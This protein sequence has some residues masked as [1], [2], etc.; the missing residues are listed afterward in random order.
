MILKQIIE[1]D[2][3]NY[4]R[5]S[6]LLAFP[7]CTFKCEKGCGERVCHNGELANTPN[8]EADINPLIKHYLDNPITSAVVCA[9]LEP[10]DSFKSLFDFIKE[11]RNHTDNDVV[12]YTGYT[13]SE[14][15]LK[16]VL[17]ENYKNIIIKF[18]RYI[19]NQTKHYDDVLG[20][21]LASD[22]QYGKV[23]S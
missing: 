5:P 3:T 19:P 17:L 1:E 11:L 21:Y 6:M 15:K 18:G 4:K 14:V 16:V 9:G 8:I 10:F 7:K 13:E 22:N 20:V 2:F 12:I 23:V